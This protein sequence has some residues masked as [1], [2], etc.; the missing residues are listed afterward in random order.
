MTL[1][2]SFD[3]MGLA[4]PSRASPIQ[5]SLISRSGHEDNKRHSRSFTDPWKEEMQFPATCFLIKKTQ[6]TLMIQTEL[7][8]PLRGK[9][10]FS[11][12][13]VL[14]HKLCKCCFKE[15]LSGASVSSTGHS[16]IVQ[17]FEISGNWESLNLTDAEKGF[18]RYPLPTQMPAPS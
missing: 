12:R 9:T 18:I 4:P 2:Q 15:S 11:L 17:S 14:G 8:E 1:K 13:A 6:R 10:G 7:P 5:Q 16:Q 3:T